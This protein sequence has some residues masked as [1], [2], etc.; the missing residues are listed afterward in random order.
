[1]RPEGVG[2]SVSAGQ[3]EWAGLRSV[4]A[5]PPGQLAGTSTFSNL[6][7]AVRIDFYSEEIRGA[8]AL[9]EPC[10]GLLWGLAFP[11]FLARQRALPRVPHV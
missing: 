4:E 7:L 3:V 6:S 5:P 8:M 9:P 11:A 10:A 2:R 1:M